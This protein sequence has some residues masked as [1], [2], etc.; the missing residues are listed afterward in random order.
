M[1]VR[2]RSGLRRWT[3]WPFYFE[4]RNPSFDLEL[5]RLGD[6]AEPQLH[7]QAEFEDGSSN[8]IG[9]PLPVSAEL[10]VG[11][12]AIVTTRGV[13][14]AI[15]GQTGL[16]LPVAEGRLHTVYSDQVRPVEQAWLALWALTPPLLAGLL[17]ASIY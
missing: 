16:R 13:Y 5:T 8:P 4:N 11:D 14:S 12:R 2:P 6:E 3:H 1:Q 10:G 17:G 15:P 9:S 7:I